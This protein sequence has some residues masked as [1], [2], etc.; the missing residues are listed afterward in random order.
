MPV[1]A[2]LA[3]TIVLPTRHEEKT[4][5]PFIHELHAT[6]AN[7]GQPL[8]VLVVDDSDNHLTVEAVEAAKQQLGPTPL[9]IRHHHRP[10]D[11]REGQLSGAMLHGM[12]LAQSDKVVFKDGDGQHPPELA[13]ELLAK[14]DEGK[15]IVI[16]S[17]YREGGSSDGLDG[18]FRHFVSRSATRL[19]KILF[20]RSL[21]G[22]SDPMSGCFAVRRDAINL[23]RLRPRGFKLLL[24]LL[25]HH[26]H[27]ERDEVPLCFG[28][29]LAGESKASEGNGGEFLRQLPSL[30]ART[31]PRFVNFAFGGALIALLGVLLLELLVQAGVGLVA[32]NTTQLV[33]T[34][35]LNFAYNR[36]VTWGQ[37]PQKRL[38]IQMAWF[39]LTR[40]ATLGTSW[41]LFV[42]L[43]AMGWHH[44]LANAVGLAIGTY[45][46]YTTSKRWVF[47]DT[48]VS[49]ASVS[50]F[51]R[52]NLKCLAAMAM[53]LGLV[54]V[55]WASGIGALSGLIAG[56]ALYNLAVGSLEVRWRLYGWRSPEAVEQMVWPEPVK[57]EQ[58]SIKFSIIVP[59][60][61]EADHIGKT[62]RGLL[63]TTHPRY[64]IVVS[65]CAGD[66]P[67]QQ[68]VQQVIEDDPRGH[69]IR[70]VVE[71]YTKSSK[72]QQLNAALQHCTGEF[73]GVIDAEDDVA[74]ELLTRTE[75]VIRD[76]NADIVQGGVQLMNLGSKPSHWFQVH[77]LLEY[78][79]WFTSRM[80]YQA[81]AGFV[82][83]GGNTV[84]IR[85]E[86]LVRAGGWP[87][88]LTEDCALGVRLCVEHGAKVVAA[89]SADMATREESPATI[90]SKAKGSLFHQRTRWVQGFLA[91]FLKRLWRKM[92]TPRQRFLA[93]YILAT[94]LLQ[95]LSA[96]ALPV[97][98][99]TALLLKLPMPITLAL[100]TPFV[101]I[102]LTIVSQLVGLRSFGKE[103]EQRVSIWHYASVLFLGWVYQ[104]LLGLAALNAVWRHFC[105]NSTWYKT[106]RS[107]QHRGP[108]LTKLALEGV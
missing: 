58:A 108:A 26:P 3:A 94:P 24:E 98:I 89:Y 100:F 74:T 4:I 87:L 21:R 86:L 13:P 78:Y 60:L 50:A 73:V 31:V 106:G 16:G 57:P 20:P 11:E 53:T 76:T 83:L 1:S 90:W 17:R 66:W 101:P 55:W 93:G 56:I 62:L 71:H 41:L 104:I 68:A 5:G 54:W 30:R 27:L 33:A 72:P 46:N 91:E 84:F 36:R 85:R 77:N 82:P 107:G 40:V 7:F 34:L 12:R 37:L 44:Q 29:R 8:E 23:D 105:G 59:A 39:G 79:F 52:F 15:H 80:A 42:S 51:T 25:A 48:P 47:N 28:K 14:L 2:G 18:T 38:R 75:A 102:S 10:P 43:T 6:L 22:I 32:A 103:F 69:R 81:D 67:T 35:L 97:A 61:D 49:R 9:V 70:I 95:A 88:S 65:L 99:V 64:E 45:Y 92:P 19:T 96:V 63:A